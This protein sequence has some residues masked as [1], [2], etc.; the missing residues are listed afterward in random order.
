MAKNLE[1]EKAVELR[2]KGLSYSEILDK[3]S[4]AKSTLSLWLRSVGLSKRQKQRL[5]E[6]K[7]AAMKRGWK[8]CHIKR[9]LMTQKIKSKAKEEVGRLTKKDVWLIGIALYWAEGS[10][11]KKYRPG[12][13]V[14][15]SN[16]DPAMIKIF[17]SWLLKVIKIPKEKIDFDIYIHESHKNNTNRVINYWSDCTIFSRDNFKHI[18][19]KKNKIKT[20]RKNIG[21]SYYG[22]LRIRVKKSSDLNR[23]IQGWIDG[24]S[25][26]CRVV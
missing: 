9:V 21:E 15:F 4:V 14:Q 11:E 12:S 1:K 8:A 6:K 2:K 17:L 5:T 23:K 26:Y 20:K 16:S 13:G 19:F 7:L 22:L 10:K 25:N 3:I 18:Y 24:I